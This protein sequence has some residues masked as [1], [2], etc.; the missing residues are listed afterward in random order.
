MEKKIKVRWG[1]RMSFIAID[2]KKHSLLMDTA[3][4]IG[5]DD[6][7]FIPSDLLLVSLGGC[8]GVD[9]VGIL[10]KQ[11]QDIRELDIEVIGSQVDTHP[12]YFTEIRV[13]YVI[14]GKGIKKEFVERAIELSHDKYCS[15]GQTIEPKVKIINTYRIEEVED[16]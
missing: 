7:A 8:N 1:G 4:R 5:G 14:R 12:K 2:E 10:K 16:Q 6:A 13:E 11:K 9:I 3:E 15:V